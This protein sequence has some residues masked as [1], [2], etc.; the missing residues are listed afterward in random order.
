MLSIYVSAMF[1]LGIVSI[2]AYLCYQSFYQ[3]VSKFL[4][5]SSKF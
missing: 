5:E 1:I 2:Y 3:Q 4:D